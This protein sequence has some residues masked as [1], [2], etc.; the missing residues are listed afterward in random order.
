MQED[1][2]ICNNCRATKFKDY[3]EMKSM[4]LPWVEAGQAKLLAAQV[5]LERARAEQQLVADKLKN[6]VG[7]RR[8]ELA[9]ILE[10]DLHVVKTAYQGGQFV[11]NHCH[12]ILMN[13]EQLSVVLA[14]TS[15]PELQADFNLFCS[16]YLRIHHLMKAARWLTEEEVSFN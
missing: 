8:K 5:V 13:H 4:V 16:T 11:G 1:P 6:L 9:R 2:R 15:R 10:E 14:S 3:E 7:D 12:R